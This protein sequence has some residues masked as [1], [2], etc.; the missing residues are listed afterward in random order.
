LSYARNGGPTEN[1]TQRGDLARI[2]CTPVPGPYSQ[3]E[4]ADPITGRSSRGFH[5]HAR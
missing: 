4:T 1:R 5:R 3:T 2:T